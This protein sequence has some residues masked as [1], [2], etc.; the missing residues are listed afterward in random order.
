[1][2]GVL[3]KGKDGAFSAFR[4]CRGVCVVDCEVLLCRY[5][6]GFSDLS[7]VRFES[8][9]SSPLKLSRENIRIL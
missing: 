5:L 9:A 6:D 8:Y 1:M 2:A 3:P 7:V 4:S